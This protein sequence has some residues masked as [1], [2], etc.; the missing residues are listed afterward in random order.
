MKMRRVFSTPDLPAAQRAVSA[1]KTAGIADDDISLLARSDIEMEKIPKD[2]I[3]ASTDFVGAAMRGA[4]AGGVIGLLGG[5]V[6][7]A[8]PAIGITVAGVA[9][10]AVASSAVAGWSA[11]LA[12][13]ALPSPVRRK[14]EE[15]IEAG[16]ILVVVDGAASKASD[17]D[18]AIVDAGGIK[19]PFEELS[20]LA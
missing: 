5:L 7:V 16:R 17:V 3:D 20:I 10:I 19:L 14:F 8:I 11:A 15:E 1:A 13:S 2:R 9:L 6:A 12:G 18:E 4:G